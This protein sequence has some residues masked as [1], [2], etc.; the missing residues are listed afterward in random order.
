VLVDVGLGEYIGL[1]DDGVDVTDRFS[2][3]GVSVG[4]S[5]RMPPVREDSLSLNRK[6]IP[7]TATNTPPP[8]QRNFLLLML[9]KEHL[10]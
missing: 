7:R 8:A 2:M 6:P 1:R 5:E 3:F 9:G 10:L 4:S